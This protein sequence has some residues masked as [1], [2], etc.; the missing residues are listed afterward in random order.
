[1]KREFSREIL[2]IPKGSEISCSVR[3][4]RQRETEGHF[5]S[6][7]LTSVLQNKC[8][9]N[10]LEACEISGLLTDRRSDITL[11]SILN[12]YINLPFAETKDQFSEFTIFTNHAEG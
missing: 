10:L 8:T 11:L 4:D 3:K 5:E 9:T 1:M 7:F 2:K 12:N 6:K